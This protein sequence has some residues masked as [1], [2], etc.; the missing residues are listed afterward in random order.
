MLSDV[1]K[2]WAGGQEVDRERK[3]QWEGLERKGLV[4]TGREE[5]VEG[6]RG[7]RRRGENSEGKPRCCLLSI[8]TAL[9]LVAG[10]TPASI[11]VPLIARASI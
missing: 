3:R 6:E 1:R 5:E 8:A 9:L 4:Y 10:T 7:T 2:H 11:L